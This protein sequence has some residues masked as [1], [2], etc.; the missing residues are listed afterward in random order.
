MVASARGTPDESEKNAFVRSIEVK[1]IEKRARL[2]YIKGKIQKAS[3]LRQISVSEQLRRAELSADSS[4]DLLQ[5]KLDVLET[6][7]D[8]S[9]PTRRSEVE[10][11]WDEVSQ[12]IKKIVARFP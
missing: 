2:N 4:I 9:W 7:D 12:A 6:A 1:L 8:D 5:A 10:A 3:D 11:A